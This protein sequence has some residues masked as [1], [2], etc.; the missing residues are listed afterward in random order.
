MAAKE[1]LS[2]VYAVPDHPWMK[3][4]DK[5]AVRIAMTVAEKGEHEG[6]LAEV[7]SRGRS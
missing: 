7:V 2:L 3:A 5:A 1:P 6:V 4:A